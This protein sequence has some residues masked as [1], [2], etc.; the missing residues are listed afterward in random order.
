MQ[1]LSRVV[2]KGN[3]LFSNGSYLWLGR[4]YRVDLGSAIKTTKLVLPSFRSRPKW[5]MTDTVQ[6]RK[7]RLFCAWSDCITLFKPL[8]HWTLVKGGDHMH[9]VDTWIPNESHVCINKDYIRLKIG[10]IQ[11]M[12]LPQLQEPQICCVWIFDLQLSK[13]PTEGQPVGKF[14]VSPLQSLPKIASN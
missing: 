8:Y 2:W 5:Q 12:V 13:L 3:T 1:V 10:G 9:F 7:W 4:Q 11:A 6:C 14:Y